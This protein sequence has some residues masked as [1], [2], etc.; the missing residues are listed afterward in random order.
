MKLLEFIE[1]NRDEITKSIGDDWGIVAE[2]DEE[3]VDWIMNDEGLY[4]WAL[5]NGVSD[6]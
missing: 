5:Q 1:E 3:L 6:I 2:D 4:I